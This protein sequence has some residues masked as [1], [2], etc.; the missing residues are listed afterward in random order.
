M[1]FKERKATSSKDLTK[2]LDCDVV[3]FLNFLLNIWDCFQ[4]F[5]W[6]KQISEDFPIHIFSSPFC[7]YYMNSVIE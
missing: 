7:I 4:K 6:I 5:F 3:Y 2:L 1:G